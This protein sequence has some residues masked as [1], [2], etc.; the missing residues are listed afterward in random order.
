MFR[1]LDTISKC[2]LI[3]KKSCDINKIFEVNNI[4]SEQQNFSSL[5]HMFAISHVIA[6]CR[7]YDEF[8]ITFIEHYIYRKLLAWLNGA[9]LVRSLALPFS[10]TLQRPFVL[11]NRRFRN[12]IDDTRLF[13]VKRFG[14]TKP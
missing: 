9:D 13:F 7:I 14:N 11:V 10:K 2:P 6:V 3:H 5:F 1:D 4:S 8:N 12:R